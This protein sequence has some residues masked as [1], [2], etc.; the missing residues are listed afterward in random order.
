MVKSWAEAAHSIKNSTD[1]RIAETAAQVAEETEIMNIGKWIHSRDDKLETA[2]QP[3]HS[4]DRRT[5]AIMTEITL[6]GV[7]AV[8]PQ[9]PSQKVARV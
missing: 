5:P 9:A 2:P 1:D 4:K 8:S 3:G 7:E 6:G